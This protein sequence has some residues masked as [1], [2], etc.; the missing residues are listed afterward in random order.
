MRPRPT[1]SAVVSDETE[2]T[3]AG[4]ALFVDPPQ[5]DAAAAIRRTRVDIG[6]DVK[7]LTG[8]NE[9]V[10]RHVCDAIGVA[11]RGVL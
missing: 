2:L 3:F 1:T 5:S 4:F 7:I 8:D 11:D 6:V 10:A 9:R